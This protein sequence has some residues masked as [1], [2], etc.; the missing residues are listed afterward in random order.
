MLINEVLANNLSLAEPD[1]SNPDWVELYN[2]STN[3]VDLGDMSLTDSTLAPRR[4]VIP[5]G[6]I[7]NPLGFLKFRFN[8]DA[9][10]SATNTGFALKANGGGV[11]LFN[12]LADG[13]S[14]LSSVAYGLQA[15]DYSIGRV[16]NG[17]TNWVL[18]IPTL[19]SGNIAATLGNAFAL[20]LNE[21]MANPSS[22]QDYFEV[23]NP[24]PQ[25]V[26][27]SRFYLTDNLALRTKH[28]LPALSFMGIGE[29]AYQKF[30]AD[31]A[32]L[33]GADHVN[34]SL[35]AGGEALGLTHS[36]LTAIDSI[37]F[38]PQSAGVSQGRLPDGAA[39]IV[40]FPLTPTPGNGNFLPL[41]TVVINELLAHTDLPLEDAVEIYNTTGDTVD[42]SGWYLS[43]SQ[44]NLFKYRIPSNTVVSAGG[45]KVIY[46]VDFNGGAGV[47]FSFSSA[48]GDEVYL[49]Q[50]LAPGTAT[51]Y[52]AFAKFGAS[53]NGVSFGRFATSLGADF[54]AMSAR[55]FGV[56]SPAT[57]AQFRTG[58]GLTNAYPKVGPLVINE[59][60]Y[61]PPG[62]SND[63]SEFVELRN[64]TASP[65]PLFDTNNPANTWRLRK[66]ID[67]NFPLNT[68]I[69]A[70]GYLVLVNFDPVNDPASLTT[71]TNA[72]GSAMTLMG[73]YSGRLNNDGEDVEIQRPDAPQTVPGPD[74]GLV[75][76]LIV[77]RI[78]Y[79][80]VFPWP[81]AADGSGWSMTKLTS[82]LYGN[83]PL[84]WTAN[85]PTPG[86]ANFAAGT[87]TPPTLT[88]LVNRSVHAGY[89][90]SF[91][92]PA[93]DPDMPGQSL[94]YSLVNTVP[95]G[96]T[97][98]A[99]SGVFNWTPTTNQIAAHTLTV[100]ATDN[101]VPNLSDTK[102]FTL[103][104]LTLPRVRSV[105]VTNGVANVTWESFA[106]RRYKIFTTPTLTPA[107]WVQVG[108]DIIASG[109]TTSIAVG[110]GNDPTR[111]YQVVSFDQ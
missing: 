13:G 79:R 56:D 19:G 10:A 99:S 27:I 15:A 108:G 87:N 61:N 102:S 23:F 64:V 91:T 39:G 82:T 101:G 96:A 68:T 54:T 2:P 31:S 103:T 89:P 50:S 36:N 81:Q 84:N 20:R 53:A 93:T 37:S 77:D 47:P 70:G 45:S 86:A 42:I 14:V 41:T 28:Q 58:G 29:D 111:F 98:G 80:D 92:A 25:P 60:M 4:W 40:N 109:L 95:S 72:Y 6:T 38:G 51:G 100:R 17:S 62:V 9:P 104:V 21:W 107:N 63:V 52:R 5:S 83:E 26:D 74:F 18:N 94:T 85:P 7:L 33:A 48:K 76:Y 46:E 24:N 32:P 1:G 8:P 90:V 30:D 12:R 43:D 67:F 11:F 110:S 34:F 44:D 97:I 49:S 3:A 59:V 35:A 69:P 106:G 75:P 22:G 71:F 57:V 78:D 66:G 55:T 65:L 105:I 73:P 88:A 16:P